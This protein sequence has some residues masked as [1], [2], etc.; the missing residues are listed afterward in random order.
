MQLPIQYPAPHKIKYLTGE[1]TMFNHWMIFG[2]HPD[3]TVDIA[4]SDQDII[5]RVPKH[6]AEQVIEAR[7]RFCNEMETLLRKD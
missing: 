4:D 6:I 7:S 1:T 5:Q 2:E 3:G